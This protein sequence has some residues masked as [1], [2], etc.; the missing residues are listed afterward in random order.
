[1]DWHSFWLLLHL[2]TF[3]Y[4]VGS[5]LGVFYSARLVVNPKY[6]FETRLQVLKILA[7]VDMIPRYMLLLTFPIGLTLSYFINVGPQSILLLLIVYLLFILWILLV[8]KIHKEEASL[9][10]TK[11]A[12]IDL[13]LRFIF[14]VSMLSLCLFSIFFKYPFKTDWLVIKII[15]F[16]CTIICGVG[17]RVTFK[18]FMEAFRELGLHG[19]SKNVEDKMKRSLNHAVPFV[20]GIWVFAGLAAFIGLSHERLF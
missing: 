15:L 17:I 8:F 13:F 11:L 18:P 5:D 10:G 12:R 14:I 9:L 3:V 16:S 1:M 6:S 2:L 4:W 7:W 19:S 20:I